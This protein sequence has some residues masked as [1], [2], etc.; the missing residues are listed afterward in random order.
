MA[1]NETQ[2]VLKTSVDLGQS[3]VRC[4]WNYDLAMQSERLS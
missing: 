4:P 3:Q 1:A 2:Q